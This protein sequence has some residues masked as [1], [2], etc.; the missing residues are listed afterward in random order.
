MMTTWQPS[1]TA[2]GAIAAT[3]FFCIR[4]HLR[5]RGC[6]LT[7]RSSW[8]VVL[9]RQLAE[10][11]EQPRVLRGDDALDAGQVGSRNPCPPTKD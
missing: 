6:A 1:L 3:W 5:G 9:D 10:L 2:A 7:A 4:P 8:E 11:S